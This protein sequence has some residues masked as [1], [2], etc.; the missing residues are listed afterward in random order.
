M[1]TTLLSTIALLAL[2]QSG[3]ASALEASP[4]ASAIPVPSP[5]AWTTVGQRVPD[6]ALPLVDGSGT[7]DLA[8]LRGKRALLIQFASW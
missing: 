4:Q 5:S 7:F 2:A 6:L 8:S 3:P 1:A